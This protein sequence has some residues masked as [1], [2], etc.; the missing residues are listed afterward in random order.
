MSN[1]ILSDTWNI[2]T[3]H[4]SKHHYTA[5]LHLFARSVLP[6]AQWKEMIFGNHENDMNNG[7]FT[8]HDEALCLVIMDNNIEKWKMEVELKVQKT[9]GLTTDLRYV[10]LTSDDKSKVPKPKYTMGEDGSS[11]LRAGW[12]TEGVNTFC[13]YH[14]K[15]LTFRA[16]TS[17]NDWKQF[18]INTIANSMEGRYGKKRKTGDD[19]T[20]NTNDD[21]GSQIDSLSQLY[22]STTKFAV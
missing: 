3:I 7:I 16:K 1:F 19:E 11:N 9:T 20:S 5:F 22:F 2:D 21:Q 4:T 17:Y 14:S 12:N 6:T 18:A 13:N 10:N 8:S 15:V